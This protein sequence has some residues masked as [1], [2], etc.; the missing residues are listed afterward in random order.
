MFRN[1]LNRFFWIWCIL[2]FSLVISAHPIDSVTAKHA[3]IN[4]MSSKRGTSLTQKTFD[5]RVAYRHKI[6][7]L[8]NRD[9]I[10]Q[11]VVYNFEHGFV[12][13]SMDDRVEPILGYSTSGCFKKPSDSSELPFFLEEY[14]KEIEAI[15][16]DIPDNEQSLSVRWQKIL[17]PP[18]ISNK[19]G[20][21]VIGPLLSSTWDQNAYYNEMCPADEAGPN[22]HVYAGCVATAMGQVIRYWQ[23]PRRGIGSHYYNCNFAS[24]GYGDYGTLRVYFSSGNYDFANMPDKLTSAST[25]TQINAVAKLLYHCGVSVDMQYGPNGSGANTRTAANAL[26]SYFGYPAC[27]YDNRILYHDTTWTRMMRDELNLLHPIIYS[28]S[29][30]NGSHAFVCDGYDDAGY[31]HFN[32]GWSGVNDGYFMITRLN[33][34]PYQFNASQTAIF[35][36]DGGR[37]IM[38]CNPNTLSFLCE[39][40][41]TSTTKTSLIHTNALSDSIHVVTSGNFGIS[42][43]NNIFSNEL[44]LGPLGGTIYVRYY[45]GPTGGI[46]ERGAIHLSSGS[47]F[48]TIRLQGCTYSHTCNPPQDLTISQKPEGIQLH[49][50][51]PSDIP[52]R[53][54]ISLDSIKFLYASYV[55][56]FTTSIFHRLCDTDLVQSHQKKLTQVS[57]LGNE[58]I[59]DCSIIVY[60]GGNY[61]ND[62]INPGVMVVNQ[63]VTSINTSG[64]NTITLNNPVTI[65]AENELWYGIKFS[66]NQNCTAIALG[67]S[68][69]YKSGKGDIEGFYLSDDYVFWK[70]FGMNR[71]FILKATVEDSIHQLTDYSVERDNSILTHTT[72]TNFFDN[73]LIPGNYEY[74]VTANWQNHCEASISKQF[75]IRE[76]CV[77]QHTYDTLSLCENE[78]PFNYYGH[79]IPKGTISSNLQY[80][81]LT[82]DSCD[83]IVTLHLIVRHGTHNVIEDTACEQYT[84]HDVT[85]N[86]SGTFTF[87]YTNEDG[88]P[89]TDTLKLLISNTSERYDTLFL[90]YNELPYYFALADTLLEY[91]AQHIHHIVVT[92]ANEH[93][94]DSIVHFTI[95]IQ[96]VGIHSLPIES[97]NVYPNPTS[98]KLYIESSRTDITAISIYH[99]DGKLLKNISLPAS[100]I[101]EIDLQEYPTGAYL[102]QIQT[103]EGTL[104]KTVIKR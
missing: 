36:I 45:S 13:V 31:F 72:D 12:I 86:R 55:T 52:Q 89:S 43:D 59:N 76:P 64:W 47:I 34:G 61:D 104:S 75:I 53:E 56:D 85:Y 96:G 1:I 5:P 38:T 51:P 67:A 11:F 41:T 65:N 80:N 98:A 68:S 66:A 87:D 102:I 33:P 23:Y 2:S 4:F 15:M 24:Q 100:K 44:M 73:Y 26:H 14:S 17:A 25:S 48:D 42:T 39:H 99:N 28:G 46:V 88:C 20:A 79:T 54:Q 35:N 77:E 18:T 90:Q 71:N 50:A 101:Q 9:S 94:C 69:K 10:T 49:W 57:F 3:A 82:I 22:G 21:P 27:T 92:L 97:I 78:L 83:S 16:R 63:P 6:A 40:S 29:G 62:V 95:F 60:T 81:F 58:C 74:S 84:W 37:S 8:G 7:A 93:G 103:R 91:N 30:I 32:W 70:T 19:F